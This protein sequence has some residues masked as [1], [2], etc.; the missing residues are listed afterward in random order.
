MIRTVLCEFS[1]GES[2]RLDQL[3]GL[4]ALIGQFYYY[5]A[6]YGQGVGQRIGNF[7]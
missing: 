5:D 6:N 4:L 7:D 3:N 2:D 1:C